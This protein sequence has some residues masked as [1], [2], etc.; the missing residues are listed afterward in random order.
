M[1]I[2]VPHTGTHTLMELLNEDGY[3]HFP[4]SQAD[5]YVMREDG[6]KRFDIPVR[7]PLDTAISWHMRYPPLTP[8]NIETKGQTVL[9]AAMDA[10][11]K[12]VD[13]RPCNT[14]KVEESSVRK[15]ENEQNW[16]G[17][18]RDLA[19]NLD[20]VEVLRQWLRAGNIKFFEPF[21]Y[22][23]SWL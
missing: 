3:R 1:I 14:W 7:D 9:N 13:S 6:V 23:F 11:I 21:D 12:F 19:L 17:K 22:D 16:L 20:R 10:M 18:R 4:L 8:P 2:S 15:H 5:L